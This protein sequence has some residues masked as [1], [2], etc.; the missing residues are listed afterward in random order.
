M[1]AAESVLVIVVEIVLTNLQA[2]KNSIALQ[3]E[4]WPGY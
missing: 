2:S 4:I 1:T 3:V